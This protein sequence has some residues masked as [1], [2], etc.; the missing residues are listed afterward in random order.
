MS[1]RTEKTEYNNRLAALGSQLRDARETQE[2][3]VAEVAERLFLSSS[4]VNAIEEA[5]YDLLPAEVFVKGYLRSYA[6]LLDIDPEL[7]VKQYQPPKPVAEP[8]PDPPPEP[9]PQPGLMQHLPDTSTT[10]ETNHAKLVESPTPS[11]STSNKASSSSIRVDEKNKIHQTTPLTS[12]P[13]QHQ[14]VKTC[15]ECKQPKPQTEYTASQWKKRV[16]TGKCIS[17]VSKFD[18]QWQTSSIGS[19]LQMKACSECNVGKPHTEWSPNQWRKTTGAGRCK[20]CVDK[21]LGGAK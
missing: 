10:L 4:Q 12:T 19:S 21:N 5:N 17:C 2:Y 14:N 1:Q 15:S 11:S 18:P 16:G 13:S 6:K 8:V 9:E 3:S 7:I 20:M